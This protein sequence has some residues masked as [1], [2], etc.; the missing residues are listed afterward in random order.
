MMLGLGR[1]RWTVV[2]VV[3]KIKSLRKSICLF[4]LRHMLLL[5]AIGVF[6]L[7]NE[8]VFREKQCADF[9]MFQKSQI[10]VIGGDF[11][12]DGKQRQRV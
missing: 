3:K 11:I 2:Q 12:I 8:E 9:S 4:I 5:V 6:A 7:T 10:C 1:E